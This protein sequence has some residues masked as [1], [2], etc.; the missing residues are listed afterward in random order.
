[1]N[2]K[3]EFQSLNP[4]VKCLDWAK[5]KLDEQPFGERDTITWVCVGPFSWYQLAERFRSNYETNVQFNLVT[6]VIKA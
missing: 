6:T 4:F 1:M 5:G 2:V 3:I